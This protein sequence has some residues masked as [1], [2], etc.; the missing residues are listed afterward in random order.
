M[1]DTLLSR[2]VQTQTQ[3]Q[4]SMQ[5]QV[6]VGGVGGIYSGSPLLLPS[7]PAGGTLEFRV[8]GTL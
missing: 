4:V 8:Q 1:I 5:M 3:T 7:L 2:R 6:Q